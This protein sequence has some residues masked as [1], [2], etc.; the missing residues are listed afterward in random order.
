VRGELVSASQWL[1]VAGAAVPRPIDSDPVQMADIELL[2][3][4]PAVSVPQR[5]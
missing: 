4:I 5:P 2:R 3:T 1:Q